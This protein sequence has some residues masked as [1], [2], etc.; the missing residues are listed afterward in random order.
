M[1]SLDEEIDIRVACRRSYSFPSSHA[2]NHFGLAFILIALY[3][4]KNRWLQISLYAWAG[5]ISIAQVYVGVH[6]PL[7]IV[8]GAILALI[9]VR[10]YLFCI[11]PLLHQLEGQPTVT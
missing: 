1:P 6:F 8:G 5:L 11:N 2:A 7:D 4:K 10:F 3:G 9:I